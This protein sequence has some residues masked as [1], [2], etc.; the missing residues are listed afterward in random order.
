MARSRR[1]AIVQVPAISPL[2]K[3]GSQILLR[4]MPMSHRTLA[5][6][7]LIALFVLGWLVFNYPLLALF[8]DTR[9]WLGLPLLYG[10]L[11]AAWALFIVL[12]AVIVEQGASRKTSTR[13]VGSEPASKD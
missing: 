11:F 6:Q 9:T 4:E 2:L 13:A 7:R 1:D 10:Y 8:N 3:D 5:G 12:L